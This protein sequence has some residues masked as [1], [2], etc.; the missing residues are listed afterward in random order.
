[1]VGSL[2]DFR[3]GGNCYGKTFEEAQAMMSEPGG[4]APQ[5]QRLVD[6]FTIE[7]GDAGEST[8]AQVASTAA[9]LLGAANPLMRGSPLYGAILAAA[10]NNGFAADG[11]ML[12]MIDEMALVLEPFM[13]D[14]RMVAGSALTQFE[15]VVDEGHD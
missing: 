1:M 11:K 6:A 13:R 12:D 15:P 7:G 2:M 14:V 4:I 10:K 8:S 3:I 9:K 5:E